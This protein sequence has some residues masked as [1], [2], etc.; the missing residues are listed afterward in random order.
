MPK[1]LGEVAEI[2]AE[3]FRVGGLG[4]ASLGAAVLLAAGPVA[5]HGSPAGACSVAFLRGALDGQA[6]V[7]SVSEVAA[8][9]AI[10]AHCAVAGHI[11][12]NGRIGFS[13]VLPKAWNGKF[14]FVGL[15]GF[16]GRMAPVQPGLARGYATASTDTGHVGS[17][18]DAD[19][20]L[21]NPAAVR[22][23]FELGV[24][25]AVG[26]TKAATAAYYGV[27]P[28]Y[29]YWDG[30]SGGGRQGLMMAQRFP[31]AFDGV[32]AGAPAWNY[33]KLFETLIET[34]NL[35]L[36]SPANWIPPEAFLAIDREVLRQCDGLDGVE[37]GMVMDPRA[38]RVDLSRLRCDRS[39]GAGPCLTRA[40]LAVIDQLRNPAFGSP[41]DGYHGYVLSGAEGGKTGWSSRFFGPKPPSF[42]LGAPLEW[43][44]NGRLGTEF[45][46]FMVK[47]DPNYD[48]TRFSTTRDG[49]ALEHAFANL[50]NADDTDMSP[51]FRH[52]GKL[53]IWHSWAD[54]AIPPEMSIDLYQSIL[55]D[56]PA[57]WLPAPLQNSVRLFMPP[58]LHHCDS[59]P[60]LTRFDSLSALE[61]WVEHGRAPEALIGMQMAGDRAVRSRPICAYPK[62]AHYRSGPPEAASSF[63]CRSPGAR[64]G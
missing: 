9:A 34:T 29:A 62:V 30:C 13:L 56:T 17:P 28:R 3:A 64:R 16:S 59:G 11:E 31:D 7:D 20:A 61:D 21:N 36:R 35:V 26:T 44:L 41:S 24:E 49:A 54:G 12:R 33:T 14:L 27:V 45:V 50:A 40:Q 60:G 51:F 32:I 18:A 1:F 19:W 2:R 46:R 42:T 48:W 10:P 6:E 5:A 8:A 37:D 23:H 58:G 47:N 52:G 55:R 39:I 43:P 22:N 57:Q 15:G 25:L 53:L 63:E 4:V 38:C